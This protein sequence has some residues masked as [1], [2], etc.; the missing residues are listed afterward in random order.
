MRVLGVG[1][2]RQTRCWLLARCGCW[3]LGSGWWRRISA[4]VQG[5]HS[6]AGGVLLDVWA[7]LGH[8][9][10]DLEGEPRCM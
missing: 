6:A 3:V 8:Q 4:A 10:G 5:P 9:E 7:W 1:G 2:T